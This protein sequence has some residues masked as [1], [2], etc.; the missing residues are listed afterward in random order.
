MAIWELTQDTAAASISLLNAIGEVMAAT[1]SPV[2]LYADALASGWVDWSWNVTVNYA[3]TSPV[4]A[5][6]RSIAAT[7]TGAWGGVYLHNGT[8]VSPSGLSR[9]EFQVHGGTAGGQ[10]MLVYLGDTGGWLPT[11]SLNAYVAGGSVAAGTWRKVSIPLSALGVTTRNITDV[12]IHDDAG[13]PQPTFY[14]DQV[15]LVP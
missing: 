12:V 1:P 2:A 3:A 9:L 15:E 13:G 7:F 11:V 4:Y 6:T 10:Q 14:I 5:G 8:G